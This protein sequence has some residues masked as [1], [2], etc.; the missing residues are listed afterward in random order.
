MIQR[1]DS[2]VCD[3]IN[4]GHDSWRQCYIGFTLEQILKMEERIDF[5]EEAIAESREFTD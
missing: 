5:E 1:I 3:I 4:N 2:K